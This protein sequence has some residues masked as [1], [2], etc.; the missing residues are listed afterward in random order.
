MFAD[1]IRFEDFELDARNYCLR[2]SG[3][4]LKL[5]RIPMEL[6]LLLVGRAGQLV[7]REQIIETLWGKDV[8]LDTENAINTAIRKIRLALGDDPAQP[9]FVQTV[10]GRGYRFIAEVI[11]QG[12]SAAGKDLARVQ[13]L[14]AAA[15]QQNRPTEG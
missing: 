4:N 7:T 12:S 14:P 9:R 2:R 1:L 3:A 13:S 5:E 10:T 8:Y 15:A 11:R 6:L